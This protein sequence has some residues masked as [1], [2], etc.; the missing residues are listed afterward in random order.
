M[1]DPNLDDCAKLFLEAAFDPELLGD[2]LQ[3]AANFFGGQAAQ[4]VTLDNTGNIISSTS[5][6]I[7][8]NE[9]AKQ[10]DLVE[11]SPRFQA[12]RTLKEK[13]ITYDYASLSHE[14]IKQ[15]AL[16][17]DYLNPIGVNWYAGTTLLKDSQN[18]VGLAFFR[19]GKSGHYSK[20][21]LEQFEWLSNKISDSTKLGMRLES[22]KLK[23]RYDL[24]ESWSLPVA[25]LTHDCRIVEMSEAFHALLKRHDLGT[26]GVD[27]SLKL[28][29]AVIA[30]RLKSQAL[31]F[32]D[33]FSKSAPHQNV[34]ELL[35]L[36]KRGG[37]VALQLHPI[38]LRTRWT[39]AGAS[40]L[41]SIR[42][43]QSKPLDAGKISQILGLTLAEAEVAAL[44]SEG[45][46]LR[47]AA[48]QRDTSYETARW[49]LKSIYSKTGLNT[50]GQLIVFIKNLFPNVT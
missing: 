16:Y 43:I 19:D 37:W 14:E 20:T 29:N 26:L 27:G 32:L 8:L 25:A 41:L 38:P 22:I 28:N 46:S 7:D 39:S 10:V 12:L 31:M 6:G 47:D 1:S 21:E 18:T 17:Q 49:Q 2:A 3:T 23:S 34:D 42:V 5:I 50:Q 9:A 4:I 33:A 11:M 13:H 45:I 24:M 35:F 48:K 44:I 30:T 40:A 15:H 36:S